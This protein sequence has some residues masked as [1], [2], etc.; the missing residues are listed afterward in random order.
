MDALRVEELSWPDEQ[1]AGGF[2]LAFTQGCQGD[3]GGSGVLAGYGP[4]CLAC[5]LDQYRGAWEG[6]QE[7]DERED[8]IRRDKGKEGLPWRARKTMGVVAS[9]S[10]MVQTKRRG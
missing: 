5:E 3:V 9:R 10:D 7:V 4:F 8:G 6:S 2:D 1:G